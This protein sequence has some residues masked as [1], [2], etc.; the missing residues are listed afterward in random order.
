MLDEEDVWAVVPTL[1]EAAG[2]GALVRALRAEVPVVLVVDGGST[3]NTV[4]IAEAAG[5]RVLQAARGRGGQLRAGAAIAEGAVIWFVHA[6]SAIPAGAGAALRRAAQT[7]DWGCFEVAVLG[8][9]RRLRFAAAWMN[10]RARVGRSATGDMGL[11]VRRSLLDQIGGFPPITL[12]EDL[13]FC[14]AARRAGSMAVVPLTL[15][16]SARRWHQNGVSR[17]IL[18]MWLVRSLYHAGVEPA[19]L[20]RLYGG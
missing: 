20:A 7:A 11:W 5:A 16:T 8:G 15:G 17:T 13:A 12:C 4:A 3:D 19:V 18:R 14:A 10:A 1:N 6:D 9:G 2:I